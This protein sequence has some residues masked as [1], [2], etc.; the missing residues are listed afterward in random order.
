MLFSFAIYIRTP[1]SL[2]KTDVFSEQ[3]FFIEL[4]LFIYR[5]YLGNVQ[6]WKSFRSKKLHYNVR[7]PFPENR[8]YST[9][10]STTAPYYGKRHFS[11]FRKVRFSLSTTLNLLFEDEDVAGVGF[12][13]QPQALFL[14]AEVDL[15]QVLGAH[16][17]RVL[18]PDDLVGVHDEVVEARLRVEVVSLDEALRPDGG[19][20]RRRH[21]HQ[22]ADLH[23]PRDRL[24]MADWSPIATR[25]PRPRPAPRFPRPPPRPR[26]IRCTPLSCRPSPFLYDTPVKPVLYSLNGINKKNICRCVYL[27]SLLLYFWS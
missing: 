10:P 4:F 5:F 21:R 11:T 13:A 1:F 12:A 16:F 3:Y 26:S 20:Q 15:V 22:H 25:N 14:G 24:M 27:V 17:A 18:R 23:D 2:W 9:S 8:Q 6:K 7:F 19:E